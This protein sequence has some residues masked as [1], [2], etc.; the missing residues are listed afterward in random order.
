VEQPKEFTMTTLATVVLWM[1]AFPVVFMLVAAV[2][3]P[4][5][6]GQE[7]GQEVNGDGG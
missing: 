5:H 6:R 3:E 7:T 2:A 4:K 1:M